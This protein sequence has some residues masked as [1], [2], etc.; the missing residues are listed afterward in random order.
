[1]I[2]TGFRFLIVGTVAIILSFI[3]LSTT[4]TKYPATDV[5]GQIDSNSTNNSTDIMVVESTN[6]TQP[7]STGNITYGPPIISYEPIKPQQSSFPVTNEADRIPTA[8]KNQTI[9]GTQNRNTSSAPTQTITG[10]LATNQVAPQNQPGLSTP[11][12]IPGSNVISIPNI[13]ITKE[14]AAKSEQE[15]NVMINAYYEKLE[16]EKQKE[17]E[18]AAALAAAAQVNQTINN[19]SQAEGSLEDNATALESN[20]TASAIETDDDTDVEAEEEDGAGE[21]DENDNENGGNDEEEE[22]S[23]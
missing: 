17:K 13:N 19:A 11:N 21:D 6:E 18:Q 1:M 8:G 22:D 7:S 4:S 5:I 2:S 12:A 23:E 14:Q 15:A 20:A 3:L 10:R 16:Q 9:Q